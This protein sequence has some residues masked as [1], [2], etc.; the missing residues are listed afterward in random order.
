MMKNKEC[1]AMLLAGGQGTRLK[2]LTK[3]IAKPA[4]YFGGKYRIIDFPLSNCTNSGIDTVG[5]LTQYEPLIL[6]D[7]IGIGD[8]WDLDRKF[9]GVSVLPPFMESEGGGWY[10]GTANAIY[11][12]LKF[13]NQYDP[14]HVLVLSGDHI[15]K[16]DYGAM[17]DY[18]KETDAD[19]T[20]SVIEVPWEEASR[21][22]IMNADDNGKITEFDEKPEYP[23][24]NLASMGV[25][26]FRWDVL[27]QYLI[28][29]AEKEDSS[30]DFGKDIIPTLLN[31]YKKMMAYTFE[32]YWK[33]VGT[34]DSLWEANM[35]LLKRNPELNLSDSRWRIYSKNPNQPPQYIAP[36]ATVKN[37][38]INEGCRIY[39]RV[40]TSVIFYGVH[41]C[42]SSVVKDSV[43][44]PDVKIG[45]NVTI[46]RAIISK[47]TV[48]EDGAVI[49]DPSPDSE[50][51]LV[52][53]EGS[54]LAKSYATN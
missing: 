17:L 25:Y 42:E 32:G 20:I 6:N 36:S 52:A 46:N 1:V 33:D 39:G 11:R 14:E 27:K 10:T 37:A 5:V 15:Y 44:M 35:D 12:N 38:L 53:D 24:S 34:V 51:T 7:Y 21:F 19:V 54:V 29:D 43:I 40:D 2:S 23:K 9:G 30:H 22:G 49:G 50:I 4:V 18:H 28:D 16:M 45:R 41:V 3:Q 47:G 48:I 13:L 26:I 8:T 31:D